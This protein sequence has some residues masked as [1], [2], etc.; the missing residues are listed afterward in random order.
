[1]YYT[2]SN[3]EARPGNVPPPPDEADDEWSCRAQAW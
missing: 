1:M 3:S 2:S